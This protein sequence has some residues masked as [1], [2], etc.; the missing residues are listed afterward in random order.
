LVEY[1]LKGREQ[2]IKEVKKQST[3]GIIYLPKAWVGHKVA[4]ILDVEDTE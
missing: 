3:S 2:I 4:I 1:I